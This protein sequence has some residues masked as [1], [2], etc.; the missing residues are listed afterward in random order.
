MNKENWNKLRDTTYY[1]ALSL[2]F[3]LILGGIFIY[4]GVEKL[5]DIE[6][7][8]VIVQ[9]FNILPDVLDAP[10]AQI[11]PMVEVVAGVFL[12]LGIWTRWSAATIALMLIVFIIAI[13]INIARGTTEQ[14]GCFGTDNADELSWRTI[15]RDVIMLIFAGHIILGKKHI[16]AL[17]NL[18]KR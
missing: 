14:C 17:E 18:R 4:A 7:F 13:A 10:F 1:K 11:L 3:R 15:A 2:L 8:T 12:I 6:G 5:N 16:V 9:N